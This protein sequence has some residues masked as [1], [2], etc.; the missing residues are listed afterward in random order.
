MA[1]PQ[2]DTGVRPAKPRRHSWE[3]HTKYRGTC[4]VC[5]TTA[6]KRPSPYERRWWTE[7]RL[8]DGSYVNNYDGSGTPP[9]PGAPETGGDG[10]ELGHDA[11]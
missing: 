7:W 2:T 3:W 1:E 6:E 8:P 11:R 10:G 4:K 9:C 5:G